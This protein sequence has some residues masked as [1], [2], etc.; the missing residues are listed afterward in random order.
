MSTIK[1]KRTRPMDRLKRWL[2][3]GIIL[4]VIFSML[5]VEISYIFM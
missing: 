1:R 4:L 3:V 5:M 2:M